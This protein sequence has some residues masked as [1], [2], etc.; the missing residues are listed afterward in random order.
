MQGKEKSVST[1]E[2]YIER[3]G[4]F[5]RQLE[6]AG[7]IDPT[8]KQIVNHVLS[9]K[10]SISRATWRQYK[11]A[12]VFVLSQLDG[13]D[14]I[15]QAEI[16]SIESNEGVLNQSVGT[17]AKK[18]KSISEEVEIALRKALSTE[19]KSDHTG[20]TLI[21]YSYVETILAT[22][23]RPIELNQAMI[24]K[25]KQDAENIGITNKHYA[26]EYPVLR[27]KNAKHTH[28]RSFGVY[29]HID[30]ANL[31]EIQLLHIEVALGF[32]KKMVI[33]D[34]ADENYSDFYNR[35][36]Q[37]FSRFTEKHLGI[38]GKN[39]SLYT[40]RHQCIADLKHA[41]L[42]LHEIAAIVG[43]G[44]DITAVRHY[45]KRRRGRGR[46]QLVK[47]NSLDAVLVKRQHATFTPSTKSAPSTGS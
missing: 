43:H 35:L 27:V 40:F 23:L 30:C 36:R 45:G 22:G 47:A 18:K 31:S 25:T 6:L 29:R 46:K 7:I 5:I 20:D 2:A 39:I 3:V 38:L 21:L 15:E 41:G 44:S 33:N 24:I 19:A 11:N 12:T 32:A 37:V 13:P 9:K 8:P 26:G 28:G 10:H 42:E 34:K 17:S 16:L 4:Q 1:K 14:A